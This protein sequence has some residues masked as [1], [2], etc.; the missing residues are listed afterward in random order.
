MKTLISLIATCII[1]NTTLAFGSDHVVNINTGNDLINACKVITYDVTREND[2]ANLAICI[3][4]IN[5]F[6]DGNVFGQALMGRKIYGKESP[7]IRKQYLKYKWLCIPQNV[8]S[9]QKARVVVKYLENNPG[10]LHLPA[11]I[12]VYSALLK[13]FPCKS[14][15]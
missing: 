6:I 2:L 14:I 13:N 11:P 3:G 15:K 4:Y 8:T 7:E 5:G 9:G 12:G 1:F 10:K